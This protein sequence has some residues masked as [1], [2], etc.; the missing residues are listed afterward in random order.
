M[1]HTKAA[2]RALL[3]ARTFNEMLEVQAKLLRDTMQAF[4]TKA[5]ELPIPPAARAT[6]PWEVSDA[7]RSEQH[8]KLV[9]AGRPR[10]QAYSRPVVPRMIVLG[11]SS[12]VRNL[13]VCSKMSR[14]RGSR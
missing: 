5:S 7:A 3:R 12:R 14:C 2:S 8:Q 13:P 9:E 6:P 11:V 10:R 1:R 4:S